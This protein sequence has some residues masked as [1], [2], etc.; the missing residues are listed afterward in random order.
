ML[1]RFVASIALV[2]AASAGLAAD[3][4]NILFVMSDDHTAQAVG[5]YATTLKS[6]NPT[7]TIDTLAAD[8][9]VFENAFCTNAICTPSRAC[10]ITGP[11]SYTHLTLPTN[12][13]V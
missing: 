9:I 8:G 10:I 13:E 12:R 6:L 2:V 1:P 3:K 7:P 11:V 4:P 5:A